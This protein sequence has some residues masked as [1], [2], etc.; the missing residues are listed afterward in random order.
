MTFHA[1]LQKNAGEALHIQA[2]GPVRRREQATRVNRAEA[3]A[4]VRTLINWAG[5]DPDREGLQDT[6]SRVIRAY[7]EWFAGYELT[8]SLILERTFGEVAG[9]TDL[10]VLRDISFESVCEHHMARIE[11][12]AHVAYLPDTRVVGISKLARLVDAFARRL[13]I[14]ERLTAE[15][16]R[17]NRYDSETPRS[18]GGC[19][20][21]SRMHEFARGQKT[22]WR[23]GNP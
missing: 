20:S 9:Y 1:Q 7:E 21:K 23:D 5:D 18:C 12:V 15:N 13:Q 3:E 2:N 22:W 17:R 4:A 19:R 16:R 11:G 10:V 6:P 14:Q 8:P